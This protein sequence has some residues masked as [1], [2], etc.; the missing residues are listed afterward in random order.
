[1]SRVSGR[2]IL[3]FLGLLVASPVPSLWAQAQDRPLTLQDC[4]HMALENNLDLQV[5]RINPRIAE[6]NIDLERASFDS[7]IRSSTFLEQ[8]ETPFI[9]DVSFGVKF[10]DQR[11]QSITFDDRLHTGLSYNIQF[12]EDRSHFLLA[13]QTPNFI[14]PIISNSF[15][16]ELTQPLLKNRG[17][18]INETQIRVAKNN[19]RISDSEYLQSVLDTLKAVESAYWELVFANRDL[20]VRRQSLQRARRFLEENR[21]KVEVGTLAPIEITTAKAEVASRTEDVIVGENALADAEDALRV[22]ITTLEDPMW[23]ERL[24]PT[25]RP[26]F[27]A[28]EIDLEGSIQT[29]FENRPN[30]E[31]QRL[32]IEN[33]EMNW[34]FQRNQKKH[35]LDIVGR[36]GAR[37]QTD[38]S[39]LLGNP[40]PFGPPI[41]NPTD[42]EGHFETLEQIGRTD[43]DTWRLTLNWTVPIHN[44]EAKSRFSAAR[45]RRE[46]AVVY[47]ELLR[48]RA[49]Q[50]VRKAVRQIET[51]RQRV[52][53]ARVNMQLQT[54]KLEAEEK[55]YQNGMSTSFQVLEFQEDLAEAERGEARAIIDYN[56]SIAELDR[57][58]GTLDKTRNIIVE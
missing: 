41:A 46:Q 8:A 49:K 5:S 21:V 50:E 36:Y 1:M 13:N 39:A 55:K 31:Q 9:P 53:A 44:R 4:I 16:L 25:D 10:T 58:T 48:Q 23:E 47:Y 35:Q 42:D 30:L 56:L 12:I 24:V 54:E 43:F 2:S 27:A 33:E 38:S 6:T 28:M 52:D 22:Q 15:F 34:K 17:T 18:A 19:R 20:Q 57:V 32:T 14:G 7:S 40:I 37:G 3:I 51:D 29:A 26:P 45:L 11:N